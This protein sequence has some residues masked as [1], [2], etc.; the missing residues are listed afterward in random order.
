MIWSNYLYNW[1]IIDNATIDYEITLDDDLNPRELNFSQESKDIEWY[2]WISLSPT[3]ARSRVIWISWYIVSETKAWFW[4]WMNYLDN[5]FRLQ[6]NTA[7]LI[8]KVFKFTDDEWNDWEANVSIK[9]PI[10]YEPFE[11]DTW[12]FLRRFT[13]VLISPDPL[14]LSST[15]FSQTGRE[16]FAWWLAITNDWIAITNEWIAIN[17]WSWEFIIT[18]NWWNQPLQPRFEITAIRE[19]NGFIRILNKT[20]WNYIQF[21]IWATIWQ[22]YVIDTATET[23]TLDWVNIM[24]DKVWWEFITIDWPTQI[25]VY[26]NDWVFL[27]NDIA[28]VVYYKNILL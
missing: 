14:L 9:N 8:T 23:A 22:V 3:Y 20:T 19:I 17:E 26:D 10:K 2:H 15:E 11:T 1:S 21:N 4:K 27:W 25:E 6:W 12:H 18:P 7:T 16:W 13:V 24:A 5:L 28:V